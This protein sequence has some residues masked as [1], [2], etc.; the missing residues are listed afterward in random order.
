MRRFLLWLVFDGPPLG[1]LAPWIFGL[2]IR[3]WP[4]RRKCQGASEE[5]RLM[6]SIKR[7]VRITLPDEHGHWIMLAQMHYFCISH[8][9]RVEIAKEVGIYKDGDE[10]ME[11][12][13]YAHRLF[14]RAREKARKNPGRLSCFFRLLEASELYLRMEI[15]HIGGRGN[16]VM[17]RA[18]RGSYAESETRPLQEAQYL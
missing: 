12:I 13:V 16:P 2:A 17:R 11:P 6:E 9:S 5:T 3:R 18:A 8:E 1:R 14:G 7:Q 15:Y 4:R 10:G